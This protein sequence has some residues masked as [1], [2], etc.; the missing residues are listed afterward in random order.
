MH[1]TDF[2]FSLTKEESKVYLRTFVRN[3]FIV[4]NVYVKYMEKFGVQK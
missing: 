2:Q 3:Y 1:N 4:N